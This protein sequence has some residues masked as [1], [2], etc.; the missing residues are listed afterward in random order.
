MRLYPWKK[1]EIFK[2]LTP[3][4]LRTL[5]RKYQNIA[6]AYRRTDREV[7]WTSEYHTGRWT[8][9]ELRELQ[10]KMGYRDAMKESCQSLQKL[11]GD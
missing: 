10:Y 3:K 5:R 4:T 9:E 6:V 1:K 11:L 7:N 8:A 2:R